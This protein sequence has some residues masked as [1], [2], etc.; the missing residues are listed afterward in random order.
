MNVTVLLSL[1]GAD[2]EISR[3][4]NVDSAMHLGHL[5]AVIDAAFGFSGDAMH[6]FTQGE[7]AFR[8][9]YTAS[10]GLDELDEADVTVGDI[11]TMTYIYDPT[12]NWN[13]AVEVLGQTQ[14]DAPSPTLVDAAGPDIVE[15]ANG[16]EM[17]TK[18]RI[19]ARRIAAGLAPNM[20]VTPL[21]LSF[22]P[23]MSPDRILQRL[24]VVDPV[25]V[26]TRV[27][28][29]TEDLFYTDEFSNPPFNAD[30][31]AHDFDEFMNSRPDLQN[32]IQND[33][34][35]DR[36]PILLSAIAEFFDSHLGEPDDNFEDF[37][38]SPQEWARKGP[39]NVAPL[40]SLPP[41]LMSVFEEVT[42]DDVISNLMEIFLDPIKLTAKKGQL[43]SAVVL[44][45]SDVLN[46]AT[47]YSRPT[48]TSIPE[49]HRARKLLEGAGF[50]HVTSRNTLEVT[51][52]GL[53]LLNSIDMTGVFIPE[54]ARGFENAFGETLWRESLTT[55]GN[56][57]NLGT[58]YGI[59]NKLGRMPENFSDVV[60]L[61][62]GLLALDNNAKHMA[63][64]PEARRMFGRMLS[65]YEH[66]I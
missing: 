32:I 17:M 2:P 52:L 48:E 13:I 62:L 11:T 30:E 29:I 1:E 22:L 20:E 19:E 12:A 23:V 27:S 63:I 9:V 14:L 39:D 5:S 31:L 21:L 6:F 58:E 42:M 50:I 18:F 15:A 45:I 57:F 47:F 46:I 25:T 65:F 26:A 41:E 53:D 59:E 40:P 4:V 35:A 38:Q 60:T 54:W 66:G 7:G 16:P 36:N 64:T 51:D 55:L 44:Q 56:M 8:K 10:P 43:P 24:T 49:V 28:L 61:L 34:E 33:P 3:C 37:F